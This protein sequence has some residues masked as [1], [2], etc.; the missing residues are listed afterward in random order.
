M[1]KLLVIGIIALFVGLAFIP[2]FNAVS[3]SNDDTTPP[4]TIHSLN[5]PEPDGDNGWYVSD[6]EVTLTATDDMSGVK[7][8]KYKVWGGPTQTIIGDNGTFII[9]YE[10]DDIPVEYWAIDN[11]GNEESHHTFTI[12][13]DQ[14]NPIIDLTYEVIEEG[15][16]LLFRFTATATDVTSKINRVE[17]YMNEILQDTIYGPGPEYVWE[18]SFD[19]DYVIKGFIR[20]LNITD[21]Y[22]KF[23]AILVKTSYGYDTNL[24]SFRFPLVKAYDNAGNYK[25]DE[26]IPPCT[27]QQPLDTKMFKW[28]KF[29]NDYEGYIGSYYIDAIFEKRPISVSIIPNILNFEP[30]NLFLQFLDHFPLLHHLLDI[31]RCIT[32]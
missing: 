30:N 11:V 31:W 7:E 22:V 8:I 20:N 13:M 16:F 12:D 27:P 32:V 26:I 18:I 3:N 17:F 15:N 14:T 21:E 19:I 28:Y 4:V 6:V 29:P 1:K 24:S 10:D 23:Y 5:P 2:S 9:D 25:Y